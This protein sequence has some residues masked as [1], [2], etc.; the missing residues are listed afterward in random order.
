MRSTGQLKKCANI[1]VDA[2][3]DRRDDR[4]AFDRFGNRNPAI[5]ECLQQRDESG[6]LTFSPF[7]G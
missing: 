7:C 4:F 6:N 2:D 1:F 3:C 5:L